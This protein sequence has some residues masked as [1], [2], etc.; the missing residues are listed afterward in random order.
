MKYFYFEQKLFQIGAKL[1]QIGAA[2]IISNWSRCYFKSGRLCYFKTGQIYYKLGQVFQIGAVISNRG[3]YFKSVQ[4]TSSLLLF[5][6]SNKYF[7]VLLTVRTLLISTPLLTSVS[8]FMPSFCKIARSQDFFRASFQVVLF[9]RPV[10]IWLRIVMSSALKWNCLSSFMTLLQKG[11]IIGSCPEIKFHQSWTVRWYVL[12]L[13]DDYEDI[14]NHFFAR[15]LISFDN[16][17]IC[18]QPV[19]RKHSQELCCFVFWLSHIS[20]VVILSQT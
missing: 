16:F 14:P 8:I 13:H 6:A 15:L 5:S 11:L 1:F 12:T 20:Y 4:N 2:L 18:N 19:R 10:M 7:P 17:P 9:F 3:N